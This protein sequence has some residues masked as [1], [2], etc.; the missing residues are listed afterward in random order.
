MAGADRPEHFD[1]HRLRREVAAPDSAFSCDGLRRAAYD[2]TSVSVGAFCRRVRPGCLT[3]DTGAS[4]VGALFWRLGDS[5]ALARPRRYRR[6]ML[7]HQCPRRHQRRPHGLLR[8]NARSQQLLDDVLS[9]LASA[10]RSTW[11][12]RSIPAE[13]GR[14]DAHVLTAAR[15]IGCRSAASF[16]PLRRSPYRTLRSAPANSRVG[17]VPSAAAILATILTVGFRTPRSMPLR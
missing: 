3:G 16:T 4:D 5:A 10:R 6:R 8:G 11:T 12:I 1:G 9:V 13:Q 15:R 14:C 2:A 7:A 17:F